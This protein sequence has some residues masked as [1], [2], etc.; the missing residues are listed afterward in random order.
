LIVIGDSINTVR[1]AFAMKQIY[2]KE[3]TLICLSYEPPEE[4]KDEPK[5]EQIPFTRGRP[6]RTIG[7]ERMLDLELEDGRRFDCEVIMSD[8]GYKPNDEFLVELPLQKDIRG[9]KY[10]TDCNYESSI[11]GLYIVGPLNTGNDQV[12]I[13]AGEGATAAI[14]INKRL[15]QV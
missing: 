15:L 12:V 3:I 10:V 14:E 13:A 5:N 4:Y 6:K 2:T 9:F 8:F 11:D 1:L 7:E